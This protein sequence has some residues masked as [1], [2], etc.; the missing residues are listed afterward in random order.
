MFRELFELSQKER[1]GLMI[2]VRGGH[3]IGGAVRKIADDAI[4]VYN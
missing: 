3:Q 2:F 4:E 1:K